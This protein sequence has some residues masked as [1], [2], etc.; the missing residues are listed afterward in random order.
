MFSFVQRGPRARADAVQQC[1]METADMF[2]TRSTAQNKLWDPACVSGETVGYFR[3]H[4]YLKACLLEKRI[5]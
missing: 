3:K 5:N 2:L 4:P 1:S